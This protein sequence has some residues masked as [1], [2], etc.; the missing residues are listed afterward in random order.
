MG[1][2]SIAPDIRASLPIG[3][4][5]RGLNRR[6]AAAYVGVSPSVFDR[7]IRD[8]LMPKPVRV[9][10]RTV[11]DRERLDRAFAAL[12]DGAPEPDKWDRLAL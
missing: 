4:V 10:N 3:F 8:G 1:G 12:S 7:M 11:W 6:A 5:P 9:Y 2:M